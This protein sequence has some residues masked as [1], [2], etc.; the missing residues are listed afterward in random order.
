MNQKRKRGLQSGLNE[1][2]ARQTAPVPDKS[3]ESSDLIAKFRE[4]SQAE[5]EKS[6]LLP[7]PTTSPQPIRQ[8]IS[9]VAPA[10]DFARVANSITRDA[11][12]GG[13][14]KGT[15]KK[16]YDALYLRTRGA[17]VP[18]REIKAR[19]S[20][21]M[22]WAGVSHNTLR[23]HIRHLEAVRLI[24]IKWELGDNDGAVYEVRLPEEI[25]NLEPPSTPLQPPPTTNQKL[26]SPSN[27]KL[28][29]G[30]GGQTIGNVITS[31]EP[32]TSFKTNTID[33]EA[34]ALSDFHT[35]LCE[36]TRKLT[37]RA[38]KA[39]DREQWTELAKLIVGE[40]NEAAGRAGSVSSVPAFLAA[41]L[42]RKF[43][44]PGSQKREGKSPAAPVDVSAPATIP[45]PDR[46]LTPAEIA[47]QSRIIAELLESGYTLEQAEEQFAGSYHPDDWV[48][49]R[50]ATLA[51]RQ[52]GK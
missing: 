30:G 38:P 50:A 17:I 52:E 10:R 34:I 49:I 51:P 14:F 5:S 15:S 6:D 35:A 41:H 21:L 12:P 44:K 31:Q 40:L 39:A 33:D 32:K 2:V 20:D 4:P 29:V 27:Q 1:I 3:K 9:T 11:L 25:V 7:P 36:A 42:K 13:L 28:V 45:D 48:A 19:Q 8:P 26:G 22:H 16:L 24:E 43:S 47:E 23:A 37:G 46:R 18:L